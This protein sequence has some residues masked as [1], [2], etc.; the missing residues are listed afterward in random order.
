MIHRILFATL[1]AAAL[2]AQQLKVVPAGMDFV[3]GPAVSTPPFS[4]V[5]SG[6]QLLIDAS[7]VTTSVGFLNG[8]RFRPSQMTGT[9]SSAAFT[10]N[11][12][13][14]VYTVPTTAAAFEASASPYD[15]N[16]IIAGATPTLVFNGPMSFPATGPLAVAPAP[17]S[18][19]FPFTTPYVF[20]GTQG[21]LLIMIESTDT[22]ATGG[23]FRI[24]AVQFRDDTIT[25]IAAAID[26]A[27][28]V[29]SGASLSSAV[30]AT[31]LVDGGAINVSLAS[32]P[33]TA[34]PA[35]IATLGLSRADID[36]AILGLPGCTGRAGS[37]DL[38]QFAVATSGVY[39][40]ISWPIPSSTVF[41]GLALVSQSLGLAASGNFAD[42]AVS[43]A[44]ALRIGENLMPATV[45][46][47]YGFHTVTTSVN[48][49]FHG[50]VGQITPV[51]ELDGLFP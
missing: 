49:W 7:Q 22:G 38:S 9:Q 6:I 17:F 35:A 8:I 19:H 40:V 26:T 25:G 1:C 12:Q 3:E 46:A 41:T 20:D 42:S 44:H 5:T 2:P 4:A 50:T 13:I 18:I 30:D 32:S 23:T 27:G 47:M 21:N 45:T 10:K 14:N 11:Y 36:L 24:D 29:V 34:F 48:A 15:L 51:V 43:N 37:L 33:P 31:Q 28:C 16:A 39:P